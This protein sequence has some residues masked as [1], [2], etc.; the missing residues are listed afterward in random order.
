M[1]LCHETASSFLEQLCYSIF[2]RAR[3][4]T[5]L[6]NPCTPLS[7]PSPPP[8]PVPTCSAGVPIPAPCV[9]NVCASVCLHTT[10]AAVLGC[11][12]QLES[13]SV[14]TFSS[15]PT[16]SLPS[17]HLCKVCSPCVQATTSAEQVILTPNRTSRPTFSLTPTNN[18]TQT[19]A[20]NPP[21]HLQPRTQFSF[22][23]TPSPRV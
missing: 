6:M 4:N 14:L 20:P 15:R 10:F 9:A 18:P 11:T 17:P 7:C 5:G 3:K 19:L 13:P 12:L 1:Q 23:P 21:P 16:P 2:T 8:Q 22:I